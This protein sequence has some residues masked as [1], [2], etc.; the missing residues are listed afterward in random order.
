[1]VHL[2]PDFSAIHTKALLTRDSIAIESPH[3]DGEC[4]VYYVAMYIDFHQIL[5][6]PVPRF[7][8]RDLFMRYCGGGVGHLATWQCNKM[9]LADKHTFQ[10]DPQDSDEDSD[11]SVGKGTPGEGKEEGNEGNPGEGEE[12]GD[13]DDSNGEDDGVREEENDDDIAASNNDVNVISA[14]GFGDL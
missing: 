14:V 13:G 11:N 3:P 2:I 1:M 7:S 8:D 12:E 9:L 6:H 10:E 4:P 5:S